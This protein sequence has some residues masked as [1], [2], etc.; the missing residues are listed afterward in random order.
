M[1]G[2]PT[3]KRQYYFVRSK[4]FPLPIKD[5]SIPC[6]QGFIV[7]EIYTAHHGRMVI[8]NDLPYSDLTIRK[9]HLFP[10]H[11]VFNTVEEATKYLLNLTKGEQQ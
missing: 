9:D 11:Q 5:Q 3:Y 10:Y 2:E 8:F 4:E 6:I 7:G 1:T